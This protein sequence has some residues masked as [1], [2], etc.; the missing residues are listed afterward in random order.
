MVKS[1]SALRRGVVLLTLLVLG[2]VPAP[3]RRAHALDAT[4][5]T[6]CATCEFPSVVSVAAQCTG[7]YVGHG[8]ILTAAHCTDDVR[9]GRSRVFFG[10]DIAVPAFATR[11]ARCVRH[12]D[13]EFARN[14][15]GEDMYEG[16][17][18]AFCLLDDSAPLPDVPIVPPM[19]PIGCERDWLAQQVVGHTA[20]LT[21]VGFG[22]AEQDDGSGKP[23]D[24]GV[25][26]HV[27]VQLVRQL[28]YAGSP[29]KLE[30]QRDGSENTALM[31]GDSGGPYFAR[32]PDGTWRLVGLHHGANAGVAGAFVES[33]APYVHWIE[34]A[35]GIDI[36]PC[37]DFVDGTWV[38]HD[39]C[40]PGT[41]V[42]ASS[43]GATW[44]QACRSPL[45]AAAIGFAPAV[46]MS[47]AEPG[48]LVVPSAALE[49][50][51]E[52]VLD[53]PP[54]RRAARLEAVRAEL[55]AHAFFPFLED[56][57]EDAAPLAS[58][59]EL[60]RLRMRAA[61]ADEDDVDDDAT[62]APELAGALP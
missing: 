25:K 38:A 24:A 42:G 21:A 35:S 12:P 4:L 60:L 49:L 10:E 2:L 55:A 11:I 56:E 54:A 18:L 58:L 43:I 29:T 15:L 32:L 44:D 41:L 34:A 33:V 8:M 51:V 13:G 40:P 1:R 7:V 23:C 17:D 19:L 5:A 27:A 3:A 52:R 20:W 26:R 50:A 46:C 37:H 45:A 53:A 61:A 47:A 59:D 6:E 28:D 31:A 14:L 57:L 22:C 9:E 62:S 30:L 36:T 16:V 39:G 48:E